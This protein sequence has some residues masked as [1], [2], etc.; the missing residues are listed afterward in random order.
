M[1][2]SY[3]NTCLLILLFSRLDGQSMGNSK[4]IKRWYWPSSNLQIRAK[5]CVVGHKEMATSAKE[6]GGERSKGDHIGFRIR[7]VR[8]NIRKRAFL[9]E[10]GACSKVWWSESTQHLNSEWPSVA[11][12]EGWWRL[13]W[14][15]WAGKTGWIQVMGV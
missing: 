9:T 3:I 7:K 14:E 15:G 11:R 13:S 1:G 6:N 2:S 5:Q 10:A 12:M 4:V 8:W